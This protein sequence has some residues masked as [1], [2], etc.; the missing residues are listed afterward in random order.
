MHNSGQNHQFPLVSLKSKVSLIFKT[1]LK[2]DFYFL[3]SGPGTSFMNQN[4][5]HEPKYM[6]LTRIARTEVNQQLT[7]GSQ[8]GLVRKGHGFQNWNRNSF[9]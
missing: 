6:S 4:A 8:C 2:L 7:A 5:E 9:I 3:R 1:K